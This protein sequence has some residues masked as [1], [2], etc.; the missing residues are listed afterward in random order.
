VTASALCDSELRQL[1]PIL[2]RFALRA[3]RNPDLARDLVQ[4]ALLAAVSQAASFDGRST[5]RTWVIGILSH[6]V[7]D[8]FRRQKVRGEGDEDPDL[9]EAGSASDVERV[10]AARR[11]LAAVDKALGELPE[12]E[13]VALLMV[14]VEGLDREECCS[15]LDVSATH[16]RVLLHR[17]RNRLRRLLEHSR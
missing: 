7:L 2:H 3:V 13:R 16:L 6:K 1:E 11:E 12:R 5:R 10:V 17:A 8:H 9:V 15:A 14:D 4:D